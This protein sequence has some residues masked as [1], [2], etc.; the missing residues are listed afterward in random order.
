M[1]LWWVKQN[2][3]AKYPKHHPLLESIKRKFKIS[4]FANQEAQ[5]HNEDLTDS[6][7]ILC[8]ITHLIL[9]RP[10]KDTQFGAFEYVG[11]KV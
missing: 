9:A 11:V 5:M 4:S 6:I 7:L 10:F 3:E 8:V 2:S 1:N